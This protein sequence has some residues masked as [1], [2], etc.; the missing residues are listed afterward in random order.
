LIR[1][2]LIAVMQSPLLVEFEGGVKPSERPH[3]D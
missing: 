2:R 1:A 3:L